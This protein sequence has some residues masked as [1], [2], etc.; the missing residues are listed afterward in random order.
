MVVHRLTV[1]IRDLKPKPL[2]RMREIPLSGV[3]PWVD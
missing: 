2:V 1:A 3:P